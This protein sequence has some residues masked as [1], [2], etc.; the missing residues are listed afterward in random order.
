V[1]PAGERPGQKIVKRVVKVGAGKSASVVDLQG[2]RAIVALRVN[3]DIPAP[4]TDRLLLRKLALRITWD[5]EARP[6]VWSPLGD[7]FGSAPGFNNYKSLPLGMTDEGFYSFWY[8]PFATRAHVEIVN[9]DTRE[10]QISFSITHAPLSRPIEELG[11]FHA[12]WH[13]D[14]FLD[15]A[16]PIDWTVLKTRGRGRYCGT[17]LHVWSPRGEWWGEG[18]EKFFVDDEKFPSTFGTG[19]EDYFGYAWADPYIFTNS[20]HNQPIYNRKGGHSSQNRWHIADNVPFQESFLGSLEKY[21]PNDT[22]D[23]WDGVAYWY[24][25]PGGE[26]LYPELPLAKRV[27]YYIRPAE[28]SAK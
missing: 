15:P 12:K 18:D 3:L 5:D 17:T 10:H 27:G 22:P 11:R 23:L 2:P 21:Y 19:T 1:D 26:N 8:M 7:F 16:R 24:L 14:A 9:D 13:R 28:E 25:A 4:P 6:A 20:F